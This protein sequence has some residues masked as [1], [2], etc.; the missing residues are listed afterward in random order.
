MFDGCSSLKKLNLSNF[1]TNSSI[2]T[3]QMFNG[4]SPELSLICLDDSI[5]R[6]YKNIFK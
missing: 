6:E 1:N 5:K 2:E 4:C 3:F